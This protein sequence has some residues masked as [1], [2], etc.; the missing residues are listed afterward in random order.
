MGLIYKDITFCTNKECKKECDRRLTCKIEEAAKQF[1]L[2]LAVASFI[3]LDK[4]EDGVYKLDEK[5]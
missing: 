1:G 5:M 3:C 2:P 4:D